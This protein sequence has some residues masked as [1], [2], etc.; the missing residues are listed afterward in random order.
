MKLRTV[1]IRFFR[2]FNFD[3][4]RANHSQAVAYPWDTTEDGR[5]Y[6]Y[7]RL[8]IDPELT[9]I[10][11]ANESGKSQLLQAIECA[12]GTRRPK[13]SDFCRYSSYFTVSE[14]MKVP[15][16]G[17]HF[18]KVTQDEEDS[19]IGIIGNAEITSCSS[20]RIFLTDNTES[21]LY[22]DNQ[23]TRHPLS[24]EEIQQLRKLLPRLVHINP[25]LAI[26]NSVP[27][28]ILADTDDQL[29]T[30]QTVTRLDR[31][32]LVD[33]IVAGAPTLLPRLGD[34]AAL[35]EKL[36]IILQGT[37]SRMASTGTGNQGHEA[38]LQLAHNLLMKVSRI[39]PSAF[40]E[41][42]TALRRADEGMANAI[43]ATMNRHIDSH[44]NLTKWWSQDKQY[45]KGTV[46]RP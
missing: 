41:L 31:W 21:Y 8:D 15:H 29:G 38:E 5:F 45:R 33:P 16:F 24:T 3:Y 34:P 44:L 4:L 7:I 14:E 43:V 20:F 11:G 1:Y 9:C 10:V 40:A 2:A 13:P 26:P 39:H 12:M 6:P 23:S 18:D 27:I 36:G 32:A 37:G 28:S 19:I 35:V 22:L 30:G 17:L 25:N 42:Q 46:V